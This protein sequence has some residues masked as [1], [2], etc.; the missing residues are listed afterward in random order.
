MS[1]EQELKDAPLKIK[2]LKR[3][4]AKIIVGHNEVVEQVIVCLLSG[5]HSLLEGVPGIGKTILVKTI[6]QCLSLAFSRIQFTP[7]LMPGD[8][9]GTNII[10]DD[11]SGK[12]VFQFQPGPVFYNIILA[13]EINRATPK[14]Q[15]ALLES[16]QEATVT[17]NNVRYDL[18]KPFLVLATQNPIEMEG[19]YPLPE[20]QLDRFFF[21]IIMHP[22]SLA[23]ISEIVNRT[24]GDAKVTTSVVISQSEVNRLSELVRQIPIAS[25]LVEYTG[26]LV[27]A[28]HPRDESA[29]SLVRQYVRYG[30]SPRGAQAIV[31]AAKVCALTQGRLNVAQDDIIRMAYPALRHRIILNLEGEAANI[32]PDRI[33]GEIVDRVPRLPQE[34]S[35]VVSLMEP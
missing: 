15:S 27:L 11:P 1:V 3:E 4:V 5:G 16:M 21:K 6:S 28:S 14:T 22:P 30:A 29:P 26:R 35:K 24:T 17:I 2:Q 10:R 25:H 19:T 23:E 32:Q 34:V 8:I 12:K 20:A 33:I 31:L 7:D 13:D 18:P 9:T